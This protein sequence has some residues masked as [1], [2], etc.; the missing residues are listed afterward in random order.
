MTNSRGT[1]GQYHCSF[2]G[3][4]QDQ[5]RRLIAGPNFVYICDACV[6]KCTAILAAEEAKGAAGRT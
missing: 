4:P 1:R 3:K 2:C 5:V 6:G